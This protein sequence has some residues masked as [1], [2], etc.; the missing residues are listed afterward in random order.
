[1]DHACAVCF[2]EG[3]FCARES[4]N[5]HARFLLCAP[6]AKSG[7]GRE[8]LVRENLKL[9]V[10]GLSGRA[11]YTARGDKFCA[12]MH[13]EGARRRDSHLVTLDALGGGKPSKQRR[14]G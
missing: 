8:R 12:A 4:S 10:T 14:R 9:D 13:K 7:R 2:G 1:M 5:G 11:L 6:C 3:D